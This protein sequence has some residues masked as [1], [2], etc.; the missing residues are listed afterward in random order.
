METVGIEPTPASVQAKR[1]ATGIPE[2]CERV[3]S[4]HHSTRPLLYRQ[5]SSPVL[6]VRTNWGG[7]PESNRHCGL[8]RPGC[9]PLHH[10][11][12][13]AGT[14]GL[15]P[16]ACRSTTDCS[17]LL[18][19]VPV[20]GSA[21][22]IRTHDLELMRLARTATPLPRRSVWLESNQRSPVPETGGVAHSPTDRSDVESSGGR[23]R[24][25]ASRLTVARLPARPHRNE[26]HGPGRSRTCTAP[27]KSRPLSAELRSR[28]RCGRQGSNL[29]RAAFQTAALPG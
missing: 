8:H 6:S 5:L 1:P 19:Y 21:G 27:I 15:E 25:C 14:T 12:H 13:E 10:G 17:S 18:S 29:R 22:G 28:T 23:A 26:V 3:E 20:G 24:T 16:A 2:R 11:H 4:N 7:R 9:L